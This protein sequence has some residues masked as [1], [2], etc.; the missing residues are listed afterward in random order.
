MG[1]STQRLVL[2]LT[3][4]LVTRLWAAAAAD[5]TRSYLWGLIQ[6]GGVRHERGYWRDRLF[7]R[8]E[9]HEPV[10]LIPLELRYG[11]G[12]NGG[13]GTD[14]KATKSDWIRYEQPVTRYDGGPFTARIG[15]QLEL[16]ILKTNVSYYLFKTSWADMHTGLNFRYS[17]IFFP[18]KLPISQWGAVEPSWNVGSRTFAP[19]LYELGLSHSI[20]L[21]WFEPWF[22]TLRYTYGLATGKFYRTGSKQYDATPSGWGTAVSYSLGFRYILDPGMDN[23]FTVGIELRHTYT[24]INRI[25]DPS[26]RTPITRFDLSNY[27]LFLTLSAFYGGRLTVGDAAKE[28]YYQR[29]YVTARSKFSEFIA[30]YPRHANRYRADRYLEECERKIP[31]QLMQEGQNFDRRNLTEEALQRYLEARSLAQDTALVNALSERIDQIVREQ[32]SQAEELLDQ[33]QT[34]EAVA[35]VEPLTAVS[36]M[37]REALPHFQA[38]LLLAEGRKALEHGLEYRALELFDQAEQKDPELRVQV[39]QLRYQVATRLVAQANQVTDFGALQLVIHSLEKARELTGGLGAENERILAALKEKLA[40]YEEL[41][42]QRRIDE[43]MVQARAALAAARGKKLIV[44]MTVPEV[45]DLLGEPAEIVHRTTPAGEDTQLWRYPLPDDRNLF[46]S[47]RE[48]ILFKI[49]M[50]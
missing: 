3:F 48:F 6:L 23:R 49:E 18:E 1:S 36:P 39:N 15:H 26:N 37:A 40:A 25:S 8:R 10:N 12:F 21:Q 35:L 5:T 45:Q 42:L 4:L 28:Y 41:Q 11:L 9:F 29:D 27:G 24:K 38:G 31:I 17:S 34:Q 33:G 50:E 30:L 46:L 14:G 7:H 22:L 20:N 43:R 32:L 44:G 2:G 47:F 13:G 16:D 19:R